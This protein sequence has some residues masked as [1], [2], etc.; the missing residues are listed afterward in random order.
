MTVDEHAVVTAIEAVSSTLGAMAL[1]LIHQEEPLALPEPPAAG[2][3]A[4]Y[5]GHM[6][7]L[8]TQVAQDYHRYMDMSLR[9]Y[10]GGFPDRAGAYLVEF[11]EKF[12]EEPDYQHFSAESQHKIEFALRDLREL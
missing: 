10:R 6:N 11:L 4:T 3:V 1:V 2:D 7:T 12:M 8:K 9:D 5:E